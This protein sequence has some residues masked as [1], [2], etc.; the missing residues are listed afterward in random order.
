MSRTEAIRG[1]GT[2]LVTPFRPDGSFDRDALAELIS[3]QIQ[4]GIDFLVPCGTTGECPTLT[5]EEYLDVIRVT[6]AAA[7]GRVPVVAGAGGNNTNH[8]I[9]LAR[10]LE[11]EG[12]DA[13]LSVAPYYNRPTQEGLYA[14][15]HAIAKATRMPVILYNVPSRTGCNIQPDTQL[16]LAEI[17]G[18]LGVKE[19]SG[20]ISQV[21]DI[22]NRAPEGFR[23]FSG[24]DAL[25]LPIIALGGCGMISVV[26]NEVPGMT[27]KFCHACL[28]GRCDD[29]R[30]WNRRLHPLIKANFIETNPIPV[31]AALAMM[32]KISEVYRLPLVKMGDIARARLAGVLS[33]FQLV[34]K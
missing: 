26:A 20:D 32:G 5:Q 12:I 13:I 18:I 10:L 31:K 19:A 14:H 6:V 24:D 15:F 34:P 21:A 4:E 8:V 29:A 28:E 2:A 3:W 30:V 7:A 25:T 22:C 17:P 23:V 33:D 11:D 1:C 27:A 9:D 16:R